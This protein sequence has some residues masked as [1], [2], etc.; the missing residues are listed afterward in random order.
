MAS[1][2]VA[3]TV[4]ANYARG[5]DPRSGETVYRLINLK[6]GE[7]DAALFKVPS[8]FTV[9][10]PKGFGWRGIQP[11]HETPAEKGE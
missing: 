11:L 7:P 1:S 2:T 6:S 9:H 10:Q 3:L 5:E 8:D 4:S